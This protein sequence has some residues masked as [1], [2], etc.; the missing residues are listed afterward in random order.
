M[1]EG[2]RRLLHCKQQSFTIFKMRRLNF[3]YTSISQ[4]IKRQMNVNGSSLSISISHTHTHC[5]TQLIKE[6]VRNHGV[7]A[8][9]R[10]SVSFLTN[11]DLLLQVRATLGWVMETYS[12][13]IMTPSFIISLTNKTGLQ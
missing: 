3:F 10:E 5:K 7:D 1:C 4:E 2:A 6:L 13:G 8:R 12:K 9:I 11:R